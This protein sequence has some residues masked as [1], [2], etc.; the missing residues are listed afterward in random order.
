LIGDRGEGKGEIGLFEPKP[1]SG[2][3]LGPVL[4][5]IEERNLHE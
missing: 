1:G 4:K 2:E 3:K 5:V